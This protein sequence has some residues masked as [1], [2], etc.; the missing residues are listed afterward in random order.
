MCVHAVPSSWGSISRS[1]RGNAL[2]GVQFTIQCTVNVNSG[3]RLHPLME[4]V[5]SD[6]SVVESEENRTM[7]EL[8]KSGLH[9]YT[10]SL[11]FN[12]ALSSDGGRY[13]CRANLSVPWMD[14]QP[15]LLQSSYDLTVN[16][17]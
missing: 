10:L 3:I 13:T 12:P 11:S 8:R 6:G 15:R 5:G 4:W 1:Q 7:V 17:E 16:S 14:V 2:H 9:R